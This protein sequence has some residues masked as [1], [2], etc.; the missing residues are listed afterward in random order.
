MI[1]KDLNT[2]KNPK[3]III[4]LNVDFNGLCVDYDD[5]FFVD[6]AS[7]FLFSKHKLPVY[8]TTSGDVTIKIL[9]ISK[10]CTVFPKEFFINSPNFITISSAE[11]HIT[12]TLDILDLIL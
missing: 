6:F 2:Y 12:L 1:F 10:P 11:L 3:N 9:S 4:Q 7:G 8:V 5:F